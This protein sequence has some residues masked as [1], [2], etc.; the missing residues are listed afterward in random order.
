MI[1]S[2]FFI[3]GCDEERKS[4]IGDIKEYKA[5]VLDIESPNRNLG[6]KHCNISL[7]FESPQGKRNTGIYSSKNE[8]ICKK[9]VIGAEAKAYVLYGRD[10]KL[11]EILGDGK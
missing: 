4:D 8:D 3:S 1:I 10:I 6:D 5:K 2:I 9:A 11:I 7:V